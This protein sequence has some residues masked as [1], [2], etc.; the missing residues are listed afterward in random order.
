[1]I[2]NYTSL[3]PSLLPNISVLVQNANQLC[4]W[5]SKLQYFLRL[6]LNF[7]MASWTWQTLFIIFQLCL[8]QWEC[9][10]QGHALRIWRQRLWS[11]LQGIWILSEETNKWIHP[12]NN[13][14]TRLLGWEAEYHFLK[15]ETLESDC[16]NLT[17]D[18][19]QNSKDLG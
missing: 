15:G 17:P 18:P 1:M 10:D 6:V 2:L 13:S 4:Q 9:R 19:K 14:V 3:F 12:L 8:G 11:S 16:L 7:T 5:S